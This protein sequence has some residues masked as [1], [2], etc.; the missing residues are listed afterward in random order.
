M[1]LSSGSGSS[2]HSLKGP[3]LLPW[4][5]WLICMSH[6]LRQWSYRRIKPSICQCAIKWPWASIVQSQ[7]CA[8]E[9]R[10]PK[11]C[12]PLT[13]FWSKR[14]SRLYNSDRRRYQASPWFVRRPSS[15]C[16]FDHVCWWVGTQSTNGHLKASSAVVT[17]HEISEACCLC[18]ITLAQ[19]AEFIVI[20]TTILGSGLKVN[21]YTD[22]RYVFGVC[23]A[24]DQNF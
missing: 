3:K 13:R 11:P 20:S 1:P 23:H 7:Y 15:K 21:I 2:H 16:G 12:D 18:G 17:S 5:T 6:M 10:S 8:S 4:V 22:S 19:A 24:T 14:W 9:V